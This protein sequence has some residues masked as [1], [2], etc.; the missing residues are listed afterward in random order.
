[1]AGVRG[2]FTRL[3]VLT[4]QLKFLSTP[5]GKEGLVRVVSE[6]A[7]KLQDDG[8]RK[9]VDPYG[10]PWKPLTSRTGKPLLDTGA[11]L[12]NSLAPRIVSNGF[13]I[14]TAFVGAAVHQYGATIRP[15]RAKALAFKVKNGK[16]P[17]WR[18]LKAAARRS[19]SAQTLRAV[20]ASQAAHGMRF[21]QSVTIPARPYLPYH[22]NL[23]PIWTKGFDRAA[24]SYIRSTVGAA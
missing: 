11:H 20:E 2:D 18:G 21:A 8:F 13:E 15:V 17:N 1:M 23:G 7:M 9:S 16:A 5:K 3:H 24:S 19:G 12:R 22:G 14:S 6:A 10:N 4:E